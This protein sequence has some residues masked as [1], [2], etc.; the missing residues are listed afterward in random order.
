V[1]TRH[2]I[3]EELAANAVSP[4]TK[5]MGIESRQVLLNVQSKLGSR[6]AN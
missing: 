6:Q 2:Y 3:E 4:G 5:K 1:G